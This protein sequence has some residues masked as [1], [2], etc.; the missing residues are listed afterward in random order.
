MI[1]VKTPTLFHA[2]LSG[3]VCKDQPRFSFSQ[4]A[5]LASLLPGIK[6]HTADLCP[7]L[8]PEMLHLPLISS[9]Q[10][11]LPTPTCP[12]P[13]E[14][15][16]TPVPPLPVTSGCVSTSWASLGSW[17]CKY[18]CC[19]FFFIALIF[20]PSLLY[21]NSWFYNCHNFC[22]AFWF[23][24]CVDVESFNRIIF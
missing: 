15:L 12:F 18:L 14:P 21:F 22:E 16:T 3:D 13:G 23:L 20:L 10:K 17:R 9:C 7:C 5:A 4:G 6:I 1:W 2:G 11:P 19:L 24:E 8:S